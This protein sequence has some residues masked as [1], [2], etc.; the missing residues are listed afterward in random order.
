M[1]KVTLLPYQKPVY[2]LDLASYGCSTG[3]CVRKKL[4]N[5]AEGRRSYCELNNTGCFNTRK[6]SIERMK[7][8]EGSFNCYIYLAQPIK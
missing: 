8:L 7:K 5:G 4:K 1:L 6:V 3:E 2:P